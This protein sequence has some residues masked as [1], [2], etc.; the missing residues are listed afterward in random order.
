MRLHWLTAALLL[1]ALLRAQEPEFRLVLTNINL[2]Q[3]DLSAAL[4]STGIYPRLD[5]AKINLEQIVNQKHQAVLLEN[6]FVR[7]LILTEIG[8]LYTLEFKPTGHHLLWTNATARPI[9]AQNDTGWWMVW[10]GMEFTLPRGEHG[11]TWALPWT[12]EIA[13]DSPLRK[14]L[15]LKV[16]EPTTGIDEAVEISITRSSAL[17]K[18]HFTLN[19]SSRRNALF[20]HWVNPMLAPAGRNELTPETEMIVPCSAMLVP[21]RDFNRWM[22]GARKQRFETNPLR[23]VQNWRAPGDLLAEKLTSNFFAAFSHEANEGIARLFDPS[24]TPGM[25]IWTWGFPPP[26]ERQRQYSLTP[27]LGYIEMWGGTSHDYADSSRREL[28][29]GESFRWTDYWFP[30]AGI[31]GLTYAS[32]NF[33][34]QFKYSHDGKIL[35]GI[36]PSH[37]ALCSILLR[38]GK[39]TLHKSTIELTPAKP[40]YKTITISHRTIP[41]PPTLEI[42]THGEKPLHLTAS[43]EQPPK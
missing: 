9:H 6:E 10:G 37:K 23:L 34:V 41:R 40:F 30:F 11:T 38:M 42:S 43:P 27:N 3:V 21:D 36:C 25:D 26:A 7:A 28:K 22:L 16:R 5:W 13:E 29:A 32:T 1:P 12:S 31:G 39:G 18:V 15:R 14:T 35:L 4:I 20:S 8:R 24:V 19:N 17:L 2:K 33:A